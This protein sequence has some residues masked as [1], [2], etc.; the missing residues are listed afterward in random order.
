MPEWGARDITSRTNIEMAMINVV[1]L[2]SGRERDASVGYAEI[3]VGAN[4][5]ACL[6]S[7]RTG[8]FALEPEV[9]TVGVTSDEKDAYRARPRVPTADVTEPTEPVGEAGLSEDSDA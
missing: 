8:E 2:Y 3:D 7:L 6:T 9:G 4:V 5:S 1:G